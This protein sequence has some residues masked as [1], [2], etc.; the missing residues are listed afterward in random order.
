MLRL[1]RKESSGGDVGIG[2]AAGDATS[3]DAVTTGGV[4]PS[5][6]LNVKTILSRDIASYKTKLEGLVKAEL[7]SK[8]TDKIIMK[9]MELQYLTLS[10]PQPDAFIAALA[11]ITIS[12][13]LQHLHV[14]CACFLYHSDCI[15]QLSP[16][17]FFASRWVERINQRALKT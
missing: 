16:L 15:Y 4:M 12:T 9:L 1:G 11:Q 10:K 14:S 2:S 6:T 17:T 8:D 13:V 3:S 7:D 5:S